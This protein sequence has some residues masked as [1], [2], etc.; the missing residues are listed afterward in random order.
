MKAWWANLPLHLKLSLPIQ[1]VLLILL[2]IA[3]LL[4]MNKI[5][6]RMLEDVQLRTQDS[7]TQSLLAL[8]SMMLTGTI[9]NQEARDAFF[10]R[11]SVQKGV[12]DFHLV[13]GSAV[14]NQ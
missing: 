5:E 8:N 14:A 3:H 12:E 9:T 10:N 7:A 2:P 13:R 4:V 11:M 6:S 1:L